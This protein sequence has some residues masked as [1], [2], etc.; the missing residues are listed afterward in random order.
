[1]S[2]A[3]FGSSSVN[4]CCLWMF[5]CPPL[6]L[7]IVCGCF[8]FLHCLWERC[9]PRR[10]PPHCRCYFRLVLRCAVSTADPSLPSAGAC[11]QAAP[12]RRAAVPRRCMPWCAPR[13]DSPG[14]PTLIG[15]WRDRRPRCL[16]V[17]DPP[18]PPPPADRPAAPCCSTA[19]KRSATDAMATAGRNAKTAKPPARI[20]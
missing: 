19:A 15:R 3:V 9:E 1:M 16:G 18:P 20:I 2:P 14:G 12:G 10:A 6:F 17:T 11:L 13:R 5:C 7:V 8:A 4:C